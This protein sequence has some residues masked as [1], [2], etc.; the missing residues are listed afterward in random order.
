[1]ADMSKTAFLFPGQGSQ[2]VGMMKDF[3]DADPDS[4]SFLK[5]ADDT[6]GISLGTICFNGPEDR[7]RQT[8]FT[9]PAIFVHSILVARKIRHLKPDMVA[10]HSLGEYT[11]LVAAGALSFENGL[12]LVRLRGQLM[13][14]AGTER[15]G[16][17]AAVVGLTPAAL[18]EICREASR[19]GIVQPA[20]F[21]S[22]GQVVISGSSEGV[23]RAMELAKSRGASMVKELVVSGAFHS[24][25]MEG[26]RRGLDQGLAQTEIHDAIIPVYTNVTGEPVRRAADIREMLSRQ[27]TEPVRW[28]SSVRNMARDGAHAF[29]ELGPGKVLRRLVERTVEGAQVTSFE[30]LRDI[31]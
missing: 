12:R 7:L 20:N 25:L 17:M 6:L 3:F 26:A 23:G 29:C 27:L 15:K 28:E 19:T 16:T 2:Y 8:E 10:G 31:P 11:A 5:H 21:N 14:K 30:K 9:Q 18:E 4:R 1:M 22:P 24:P 13:Q